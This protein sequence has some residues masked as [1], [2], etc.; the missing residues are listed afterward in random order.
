MYRAAHYTFTNSNIAYSNLKTIFLNIDMLQFRD[1]IQ[2][3]YLLQ[4][5]KTETHAPTE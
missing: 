4:K 2:S 5:L 3:Y 1:I